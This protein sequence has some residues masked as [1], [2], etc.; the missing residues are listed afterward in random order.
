MGISILQLWNKAYP[1]RNVSDTPIDLLSQLEKQDFNQLLGNCSKKMRVHTYIHTYIHTTFTHIHTCIHNYHKYILHACIY[2]L[3]TE[4]VCKYI[5]IR[6][7]IHSHTYMY[8]C[9]Y[10][11]SY[12]FVFL[13]RMYLVS[14]Y[15]GR[16]LCCQCLRRSRIGEPPA[17]ISQTAP[18]SNPAGSTPS[19]TP[20]G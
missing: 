11:Y 3:R 14:M 10:E 7:F 18:G 20:K 19:S 17:R 1:F 12:N 6:T 5:H 8:V 15:C 4:H 2:I 16:M 9:V 13:I